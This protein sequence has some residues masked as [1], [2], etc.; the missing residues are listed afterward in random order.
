[1]FSQVKCQ[2]QVLVVYSVFAPRQ[3]SSETKAVKKGNIFRLSDW[4]KI[5]FLLV[6]KYKDAESK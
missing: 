5:Y 6:M 1:M 4:S 2:N 3:I